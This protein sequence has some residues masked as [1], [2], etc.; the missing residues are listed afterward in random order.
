MA[1]KLGGHLCE[2]HSGHLG[3]AGQAVNAS[4]TYRRLVK[5]KQRSNI[6]SAEGNIRP[7]TV[8]AKC[9]TTLTS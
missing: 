3:A 8:A 6:P 2:C 9:S 1:G 4:L 5:L 7:F